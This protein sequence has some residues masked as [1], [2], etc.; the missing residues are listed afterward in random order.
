VGN[1]PINV[2]DS[3]GLA[4]D[5]CTLDAFGNPQLFAEVLY[6]VPAAQ[7]ERAA[8]RKAAQEAL[9]AGRSAASKALRKALNT[10]EN[11]RA[12]HLIPWA[13]KSK[14]LIKKAAEAGWN[15]NG[16]LNGKNLPEAFHKGYPNWHRIM[17]DKAKDLIDKAFRDNM[18]ADEAAAAAQK[19]ANQLAKQTDK[20]LKVW[21]K[22]QKGCQ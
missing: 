18:T 12:H 16:K 10:G 14:P 21:E 17:N 7:F 13:E 1:D 11:E 19:I 2:F 4:G 9:E 5:S 3:Y 8:A 22:M 15:M 20:A 6:D